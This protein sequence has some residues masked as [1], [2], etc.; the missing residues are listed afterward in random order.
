MGKVV[1]IP[2]YSV[3]PGDVVAVRE[4]AK[5]QLRIL[6]AI[7]LAKQREPAEWIEVNSKELSGQFKS[8]PELSDLPAEF[9]VNMVVELYSK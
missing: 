5:S 4:K 1:N 7:D 9:K 2:S 3:K 6:A 8:Y